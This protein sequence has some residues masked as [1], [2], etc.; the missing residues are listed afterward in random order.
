[1]SIVL[2]AGPVRFIDETL[3]SL[4]KSVWIDFEGR[5]VHPLKISEHEEL[6]SWGRLVSTTFLSSLLVNS[7]HLSM[8]LVY[9]VTVS[10]SRPKTAGRPLALDAAANPDFNV[11]AT[12]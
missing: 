4:S 5:L 11:S 6:S 7:F 3:A 1:M 2:L 12:S 9:E 8:R 10:D